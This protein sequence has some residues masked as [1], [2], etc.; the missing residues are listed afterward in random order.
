MFEKP[1]LWRAVL[2]VMIFIVLGVALGLLL[3]I[4][5]FDLSGL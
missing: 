4:G 2:L 5:L 1:T 3:R